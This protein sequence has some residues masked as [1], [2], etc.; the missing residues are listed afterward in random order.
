MQSDLHVYFKKLK[1]GSTD[2]GGGPASLPFIRETLIDKIKQINKNLSFAISKRGKEKKTSKVVDYE[3]INEKYSMYQDEIAALTKE[4]DMQR[5]K[6]R[7]SFIIL[8]I[9]IDV[10][11]E[12]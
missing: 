11:K 6:V 7:S 4:E 5:E 12:H 3:K 9:A 8:K 10:N 1:Q 2:G